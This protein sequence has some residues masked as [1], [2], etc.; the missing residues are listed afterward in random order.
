[1]RD[2][3]QKN[4]EGRQGAQLVICPNGNGSV[5]LPVI[6]NRWHV[7]TILIGPTFLEP[8]QLWKLGQRLQCPIRSVKPAVPCPASRRRPKISAAAFHALLQ[9]IHLQAQRLAEE[10]DPT[11][12]WHGSRE[13]PAVKKVKA[14]VWEHLTEAMSTRTA[15]RHVGLSEPYFCRV[16]RRDTAVTLTEYIA[17][18]RIRRA[19]SL[20]LDPSRRVTE[21]AFACGYQS[22]SMFNDN[23]RRYAGMSPT[24]FRG[25]LAA[26][27]SS[28]SLTGPGGCE[29]VP[30]S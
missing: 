12:L 27:G 28:A 19:Q 13:H 2:A 8:A 14:Y 5:S 18:L 9:L 20:L 21:V 11:L 7:A 16:F 25:S 1:M 24:E 10:L 26:R 3:L 17:R 6:V 22:I 29:P 23:F 4:P 30:A 15:A